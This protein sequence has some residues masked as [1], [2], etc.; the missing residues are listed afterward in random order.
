MVVIFASVGAISWAIVNSHVHAEVFPQ[1]KA[2]DASASDVQ[3]NH[4]ENTPLLENLLEQV[5]CN[6]KI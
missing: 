5:D 6:E 3:V 1:V 2:P 4:S